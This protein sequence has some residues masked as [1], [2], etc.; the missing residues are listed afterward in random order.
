M[1]YYYVISVGSERNIPVSN[2]E[3]G[4]VTFYA[5]ATKANEWIEEKTERFPDAV[6]DLATF[7]TAEAR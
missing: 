4:E 5:D 6:Y 1:V 7:N 3:T 2:P